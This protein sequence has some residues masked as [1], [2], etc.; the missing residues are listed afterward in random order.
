[1]S[2][3]ILV[4]GAT[5]NVGRE[6]VKILSARGMDIRA[7]IHSS[8]KKDLAKLPG[9]KTVE[10]DMSRPKTFGPALKDIGRLFLLLPMHPDMVTFASRLVNAAKKSGVKHIVKLSTMRAGLQH[11]FQVG[12]WHGEADRIVKES[13]I[14]FTILRP[15][16]FMQNF[17]NFTGDSIRTQDAFYF[18][19]GDGRVSFI[20]TRDVA[21]VCAQVLSGGHEERSYDLTG[22]EALSYHEASAIFSGMLKR[23]IAYVP[24]TAGQARE[25]MIKAGMP[26]WVIGNMA[27]FFENVGKGYFSDVTA[28]VEEI[29]GR[30]PVSLDR[31]VADYADLFSPMGR[32]R[33]M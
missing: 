10:L 17:I 32:A 25:G 8:G 28:S 1:M 24:L 6:V 5:G 26:E 18:A 13:G 14:P 33:A 21:A 30:M 20:D 4:T 19:A 27:E 23:K 3:K 2:E 29:T 7:G 9:V 11:S 16:S 12:R 22:P 31:F 15:N